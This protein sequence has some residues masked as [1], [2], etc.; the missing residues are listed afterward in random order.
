MKRSSIVLSIL[1]LSLMV[2]C[3]G[4]PRSDKSF[5]QI[6]SMVQG[7]TAKEIEEI[8]GPP[9]SRQAFPLGDEQWIWWNY[10]YLDGQDYRPEIRG[11]I[12]HLQIT[13]VNTKI[14]DSHK[15]S[16]A[17]WRIL[18]PLGVSFLLPK[19]SSSSTKIY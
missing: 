7:K 17:K 10:T 5:D 14:G 8:L 9:D 11:Q 6:R 18:D 3:D 13:F 1:A 15:P 2:A 12:V 16:Y 4:S 19:E